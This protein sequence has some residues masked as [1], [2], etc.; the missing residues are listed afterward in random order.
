MGR[1]MDL[2]LT[3]R[4]A[5]AKECGEIDLAERIVTDGAALS[6]AQA[7]AAEIALFPPECVRADLRATQL[8]WG[9]PIHSA[10]QIEWKSRQI[11]E[12]ESIAGA[13][14]FIES[15][16]RSSNFKTI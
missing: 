13:T 6:T 1:A 4:K 7:L 9:Q 5:G 12:R 2:I 8:G 16:E 10:L 14:R 15:A 3:G 11:L